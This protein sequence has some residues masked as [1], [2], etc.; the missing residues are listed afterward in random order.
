MDACN[1]KLKSLRKGDIIFS[2]PF[3]KVEKYLIC[4]ERFPPELTSMNTLDI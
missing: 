1:D 4:L 3:K 2:V